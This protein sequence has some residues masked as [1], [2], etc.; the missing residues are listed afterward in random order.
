[1]NRLVLRGP[2]EKDIQAWIL[3]TLGLE[4]FEI[5]RDKRGV[6]RKVSLNIWLAPHQM[7]T[8]VNSARV[9]APSG[10]LL[11]FGAPG[12]ADIQ[13]VVLGQAV[14]LEV[15]RE[16]GKQSEVQKRWQEWWEYSGGVY[17]VV[18]SPG[19]ARDVVRRLT[20]AA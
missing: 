2:L 4:Q 17:A 19:E 14:A 7:W 8:R 5:R 20:E 18:R 9:K 12:A 3:A 16:G 1:M 10:A 11:R 13:G 6:A 15:K